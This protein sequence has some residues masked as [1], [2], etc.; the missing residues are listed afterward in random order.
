MGLFN[1][2]QKL[3][4]KK[5]QQEAVQKQKDDNAKCKALY[6]TFKLKTMAT[7]SKL[8]TYELKEKDKDNQTETVY[9]EYGP[10]EKRKVCKTFTKDGITFSDKY[11]VYEGYINPDEAEGK[12]GYF[13]IVHRTI[14]RPHPIERETYVFQ[15]YN[16]YHLDANGN[17]STFMY[18]EE[19]YMHCG[20]YGLVAKKF[21]EIVEQ[22]KQ[23][24]KQNDEENEA[25]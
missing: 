25:E 7:Q 5:K 22:V 20:E 21:D 4:E 6:E 12:S 17:P 1:R 2:K 18:R 14:Y 19:H 11:T 3:E 24:Q 23:N 9:T 10:V 13:K 16:G 8:G 15:D